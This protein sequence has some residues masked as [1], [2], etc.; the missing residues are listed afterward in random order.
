MFSFAPVAGAGGV[1]ALSIEK[2]TED[3]DK[4]LGSL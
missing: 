4:G 2:N 3:E 1:A